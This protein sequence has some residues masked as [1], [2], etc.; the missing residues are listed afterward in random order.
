MR[1]L[2]KKFQH[3]P[4]TGSVLSP[5]LNTDCCCFS[6]NLPTFTRRHLTSKTWERMENPIRIRALIRRKKRQK[7][8]SE[9]TEGRK[10]LVPELRQP[11]WCQLAVLQ[12]AAPD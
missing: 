6:E 1:K 7:H 5:D 10:W 11:A 12:P 9:Q 4:I 3:K 2:I 8:I